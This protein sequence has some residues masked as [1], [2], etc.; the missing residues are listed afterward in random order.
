MSA[1]LASSP[2]NRRVGPDQRSSK[3]VLLPN[4]FM[5]PAFVNP[6]SAAAAVRRG[7]LCVRCG[8]SATS[9]DRSLNM[10]EL[11][12]FY[13]FER[14][15]IHSARWTMHFAKTNRKPTYYFPTIEL[16]AT[17]EIRTFYVR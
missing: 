16:D 1:L 5:A 17:T 15:D 6:L 13:H 2:Q 14:A 9:E 11:A 10:R 3:L 4:F 8:G 12:L 7:V